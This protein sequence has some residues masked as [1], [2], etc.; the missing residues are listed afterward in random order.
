LNAHM[1]TAMLSPNSA[2]VFLRKW[3]NISNV[4]SDVGIKRM[5]GPGKE[6][7]L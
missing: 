1:H 5:L 2:F 3:R 7:E 4:H 6:L